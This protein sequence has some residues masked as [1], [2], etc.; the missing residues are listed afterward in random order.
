MKAVVAELSTRRYLTTAAAQRL[1]KSVGASAGWSAGG[2]LSWND[3]EPEPQLPK[4]SGWVTLRPELSGICG[5]DVG[6][7]H[8]KLSLVLSAFYTASRAIPG[9]EIV[10]VV[11]RT[12]PGVT[13]VSTGDRVVIDPIISCVTRGFA[14]CRSCAEGM[15]FVCERFDVPG[16]LGCTATGQG[17]DS[18]VGGGW[19]QQLIAHESQLYPV[20]QMPSRRAVLAEPAAIALHAALQWPRRGDRVIVIGPGTIG[21]LTIAALRM[22]HP[23]LDIIAVS[24]DEFGAVQAI[25]AGANR[26]LPSSAQAVELLAA[27]DGGR[28]LRPRLTPVPILEQGVDAVFDCVAYPDTIELGLHLLRAGGMFVLVGGASV[29]KV[30]WSLVWNR[31]LTIQGTVNSG[32]EPQLAGR[33]TMSQVVEWL[34]DARFSVDGLVTHVFALTQWREALTTAS[35]GPRAG[36][37][38]ATLRPNPDLSL[39]E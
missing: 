24:P 22:L 18:S 6:L 26:T 15:P 16:S 21:L 34:A 10:A 23:D 14:P 1:P 19:G 38:K 13:Q 12:G 5:S 33:H 17:F 3:H 8:A 35:A 9:H 20:G 11:N 4:A 36:C 2:L 39:V 29:Q 7:A 30:D 25:S 31:Q 32:P 28:V 27:L 37:I